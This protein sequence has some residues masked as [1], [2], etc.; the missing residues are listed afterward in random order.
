MRGVNETV[1]RYRYLVE[2]LDVAS[3][4]QAH[5]DALA[6][7]PENRRVAVLDLVRTEL[8]VGRRIGPDA[9]AVLARYLVAAERRRPGTM[10]A[11]L[12][13]GVAEAIVDAM[14]RAAS[15]AV[16]SGYATWA[17]AEPAPPGEGSHGPRL[18][19]WDRLEDDPVYQFMRDSQLA[20]ASQ[21]P[22]VRR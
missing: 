1:R 22:T 18:A 13:H 3:L 10:V 14:D 11:M 8:L 19:S 7:Q 12:P 5:V 2:T 9:A 17:P 16:R 15:D 21:P 6:A 4:A 20:P